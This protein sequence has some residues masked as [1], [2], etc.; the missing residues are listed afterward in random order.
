MPLPF[1]PVRAVGRRE[2]AVVQR[3]AGEV[4]NPSQCILARAT[5]NAHHEVQHAAAFARWEVVPE[6]ARI[7]ERYTWSVAVAPPGPAA[8]AV[9]S[10][11]P[12]LRAAQRAI[13]LRNLDAGQDL[14]HTSRRTR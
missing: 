8:V 3:T 14:V 1:H 2:G 4:G 13:H 5:T 9:M 6:T 7:I 12:Q 10:A 11:A